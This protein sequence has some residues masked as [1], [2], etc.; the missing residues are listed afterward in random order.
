MSGDTFFCFVL[1][2]IYAASHAITAEDAAK[3]CNSQG[4]GYGG[5]SLFLASYCTQGTARFPLSTI[6]SKE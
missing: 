5:T 2:I 6:E 3:I 1:L 4:L